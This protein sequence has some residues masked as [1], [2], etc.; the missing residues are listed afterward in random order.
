MRYLQSLGSLS[1]PDEAE[2]PQQSR[3][4]TL[5]LLRISTFTNNATE[6][7]DLLLNVEFAADSFELRLLESETN[8]IRNDP[9]NEDSTTIKAASGDESEKVDDFVYLGPGKRRDTSKF[10]REPHGELAIS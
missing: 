9:A 2:D 6:G 7:Q 8:Y 10:G 5:T 3:G 4:Q 1:I